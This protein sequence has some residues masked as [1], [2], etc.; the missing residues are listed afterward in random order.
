MAERTSTASDSV[1]SSPLFETPDGWSPGYALAK[2][3][4]PG[5][6][7]GPGLDNPNLFGQFFSTKPHRQFKVIARASSIDKPAAP[8]VIQINWHDADGK[9]ISVSRQSFDVGPAERSFRYDVIAPPG[10]ASG[11]LYV[12]PG[13]EKEA[14]RYTEMT[15]A[16]L[17]PIHD[18]MSYRFLGVKV[19]IV[20][21][22]T[23]IILVLALLYARYGVKLLHGSTLLAG[24]AATAIVRSFPPIAIV[25]CVAMFVFMEGNYEQHYDSHWHQSSIDSIMQWN[26]FSL[27]FGG[28]LL[29]NF[30]IQHVINPQLSPTFWIGSIVPQDYRIQV[31]AAFQAVVFFAIFVQLC[32]LAGARLPQASA[33]SLIAVYYAWVPLLSNEY[34]TL[35]PTLGLLW[36]EGAIAT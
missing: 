24:G 27:D 17:D 26:T 4:G 36:Q 11:T 21:S 35:S 18:F 16:R 14:V 25:L 13:A 29:Y 7:V 20:A 9:F 33:I 23:A 22:V 6:V 30:G 34:I 5:V 2:G 15:L 31:E 12:M 32:R 19:H 8:A 28:N 1:N 3:H 10:A